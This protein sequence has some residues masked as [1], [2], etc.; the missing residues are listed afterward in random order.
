LTAGLFGAITAS[1]T[2]IKNGRPIEC[3]VFEQGPSPLTKVLISGG[4]RCNV[5]HDD[6]KPPVFIANEGYP[7]GNRELLGP[8]TSRFG[9]AEAAAW[10]RSRGESSISFGED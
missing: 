6:T 4:G 9:A 1:E 8:M 7:R 2:A 10:F 3:I 5:L